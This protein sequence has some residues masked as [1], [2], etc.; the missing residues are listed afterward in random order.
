MFSHS[1]LYVP[2]EYAASGSAIFQQKPRDETLHGMRQA[3]PV[4]AI[5][6]I[7]L[8]RNRYFWNSLRQPASGLSQTRTPVHIASNHKDVPEWT[9]VDETVNATGS[10]SR[11]DDFRLLGS[12]NSSLTLIQMRKQCRELR[13]QRRSDLRSHRHTTTM[14]P[15]T[16]YVQVIDLQALCDVRCFDGHEMDGES[17]GD[18]VE[19]GDVS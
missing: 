7:E 8:S 11:D 18:L 13:R 15:I 5:R 19:P 17:P 10:G 12:M 2:C 14:P 1:A 9:N 4:V 3:G 16:R 6:W